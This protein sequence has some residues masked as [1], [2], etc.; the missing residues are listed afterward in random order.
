MCAS[1][2]HWS[3]FALLAQFPRTAAPNWG[4]SG[5]PVESQRSRTRHSSHSTATST[6]GTILTLETNTCRGKERKLITGIV[7]WHWRLLPWMLNK[8]QQLDFSKRK[9]IVSGWHGNADDVD[10]SKSGIIS[11][12][13]TPSL[14]LFLLPGTRL[15]RAASGSCCCFCLRCVQSA[16]PRSK[17]CS[18]GRPSE[19]CPSH[20]FSPTC[21]NRA[22]FK[23]QSL[24]PVKTL[25]KRQTV[26]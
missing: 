4:A 26:E 14:R 19:T 3:C 22:T 5:T 20:G 8:Y 1:T 17:K 21:T 2:A 11:E 7:S 16:L 12:G 10:Q 18:S 6:P 15:S 25:G 13:L 9:K 23:L 24:P